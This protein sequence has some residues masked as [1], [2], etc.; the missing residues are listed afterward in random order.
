MFTRHVLHSGIVSVV[1][2]L[3]N[4]L[5]I[6]HCSV[7]WGLRHGIGLPVRR[8]SSEADWSKVTLT[9]SSSMKQ[10]VLVTPQA[11][12][13]LTFIGSRRKTFNKYFQRTK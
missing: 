9:A 12:L 5:K 8:P 3:Y 1:R 11:L 10:P 2:I 4:S 6:L 7:G 13:A